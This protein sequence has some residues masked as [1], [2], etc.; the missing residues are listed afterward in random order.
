MHSESTRVG[1][2]VK[3][4]GS[5]PWFATFTFLD[6]SGVISSSQV[7]RLVTWMARLWRRTVTGARAVAGQW[8]R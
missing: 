6:V 5:E 8:R 1:G 3:S 7:D 4:P 2:K